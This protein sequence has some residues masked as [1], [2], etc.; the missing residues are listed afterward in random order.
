M[1]QLEE[2]EAAVQRYIDSPK[3]MDPLSP[4]DQRM[5]DS[6]TTCYLC[7]KAIYPDERKMEYRKSGITTIILENTSERHIRNVTSSVA[8]YSRFVYLC[9]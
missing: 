2:W 5:Y 9:I 7:K 4:E 1:E 3:P 6:A 8:E